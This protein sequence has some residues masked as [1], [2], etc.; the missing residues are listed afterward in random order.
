MKLSIISAAATGTLFALVT[1]TT[2]CTSETS[3]P[4]EGDQ[5]SDETGDAVDQSA[6]AINANGAAPS[7]DPAVC[8]HGD[9][10]KYCCSMAGCGYRIT[11]YCRRGCNSAGT[12]HCM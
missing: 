4:T 6:D 10:Q 12:P 5:K 1:L 9:V 3:A 2:A 7:C 8:R 11:K